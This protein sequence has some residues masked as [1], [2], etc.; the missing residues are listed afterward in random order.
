MAGERRE[1]ERRREEEAQL[2]TLDRL[3]VKVQRDAEGHSARTKALKQRDAGVSDRIDEIRFRLRGAF[4]AKVPILAFGRLTGEEQR[5]LVG[6]L[7]P[8][9]FSKGHQIVKEGDI[10]DTL[11]I[12]EAGTCQALK[13]IDGKKEAV[14]GKLGKGSF[15]GEISTFYDMPRT[16]TV[17]TMTS[18]TALSLCRSDLVS[19]IT[20]ENLSTMRI[21]ART[22]VFS[23]IPLLAGLKPHQQVHVAEI[24]KRTRFMK[25]SLLALQNHICSRLHI[26]EQGKVLMEV[27]DRAGLPDF[28]LLPAKGVIRGPPQFFGMRGLVTGGSVGYKVTAASDEV[29]TLSISYEEILEAAEQPRE[30][31]EMEATMRDWMQGYLLRHIPQLQHLPENVFQTVKKN[32]EE[33]YIKKWSVIFSFGDVMDAVYVL[34]K[35]KVI[36]TTQSAKELPDLHASQL[37]CLSRETSGDYFGAECLTDKHARAPKTLVAQTDVVLL[38]L[39]APV[40]WTALHDQR[41]F[42]SRIPLLSS[43]ILSK[44]DQYLLVGKLKPWSFTS[45]S[46]IITQGEFGNE[47]FIVEQGVC[48]AIKEKDGQQ[49]QVVAKL[50]KGSYFGELACMYDCHR[51]ATVRAT[52]DVMAVSLSREDIFAAIGKGKLGKMLTIARTEVFAS[53]P[54]LAGLQPAYKVGV[55]EKLA[56]EVHREGEV[57]VE[58]I[59]RTDRMYIV[60]QGEVRLDYPDGREERLVPFAF[61]GMEGLLRR[62]PYGLK[63]TVLS[64]S[65]T[66]LSVTLDD[67]MEVAG[68]GE[69]KSLERTLA[70]AMRCHLL[71]QIP[72]LESKGDDFFYALLDHVEVIQF[73]AGD[74]VVAKGSTVT[75][76]YI[77]EQGSLED[78]FDEAMPDPGT[79]L[80][81]TRHSIDSKFI[82]G[83]ECLV[84]RD[85][86]VCQRTVVA[87]TDGTALRVPLSAMRNNMG[88]VQGKRAT[89]ISEDWSLHGANYLHS[90]IL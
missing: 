75:S 54:I 65:A 69:R 51:T 3:S 81:D 23:S 64:E 8:W 79:N 14:V 45:G 68:P 88:K 28:M 61:F 67:I 4:L 43:D 9:T 21:M 89:Q 63:A 74:T 15:F 26:I 32:A 24:M 22:Q 19:V 18:C 58:P 47:L 48:H 36:E 41:Q 78:Q 7:R 70:D 87:T 85:T 82:L 46:N 39:P 12:I 2:M 20:E 59:H 71:R 16:A 25:G 31:A 60:E 17:C 40:V 37:A 90:A 73:L 52:T 11:Y 38:K 80:E 86:V 62:Q 72:H 50:Q 44:A 53:V 29:W 35:G 33:V 56:D 1:A 42:I 49:E 77:V 10:G 66:L 30:R 34:E 84:K 27:T 55:A 57:L 5:K 13:E 83:A 76:V 6:K